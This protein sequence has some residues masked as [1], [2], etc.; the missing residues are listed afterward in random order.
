MSDDSWLK[1]L[2]KNLALCLASVCVSLALA[3]IVLRLFFPIPYSM[4]LEYVPDG[5]LSF[6]L[7]PDRTYRLKSGGRCSVDHLGFRGADPVTLAK[8]EGRIRIVAVGGSATF[9]YETDDARIW[10]KELERL[11]RGRYGDHI[12]VINAGVPGYSTFESKIDYLYQLRQLKP[13]LVIAYETWNDIKFFRALEAGEFPRKGVPAPHP[14]TSLLRHLQLAWRVRNLI[15]EVWAPLEREN[16]YGRFAGGP[17]AI[18]PA[19]PAHLW[20]EKNFDDLV[21]LLRSDGVIP[22]LASQAGLLSRD[23][24]ADPKVRSVVYTEYAN[25]TF[26]ELLTEWNSVTEIIRRSAAERGALF[27]D[28]YGAVPHDTSMF[29]DHVHLTDAGNAA[30]ARALFDGLIRDPGVETLMRSKGAHVASAPR[31]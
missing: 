11:L 4:E 30:V 26:A 18:S 17:G 22:V 24:L 23:N 12:E 6:R 10:T 14:M 25:L 21:L 8:S 20:E 16:R 29:A 15:E 3:E 9:S 31:P 27:I 28:V 7:Q 5:C 13:D 2:L 1:R 19:G